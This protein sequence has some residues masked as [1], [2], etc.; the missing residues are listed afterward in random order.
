MKE[1]SIGLI[2]ENGYS[3]SQNTSKKARQWLKYTSETLKIFIHHAMNSKE[4]TI[5]NFSVDGVCHETKQIFEFHGCHWHGCPCCYTPETY[6]N[7]KKN[8]MKEIHKMHKKRIQFMNNSI[9]NRV[10][11]RSATSDNNF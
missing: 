1:N 2:P 3:P 7:I 10:R 11:T 5:G 4:F 8:T 6:S 9:N